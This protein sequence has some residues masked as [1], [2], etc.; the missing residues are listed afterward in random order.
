MLYAAALTVGTH[1]P[2]LRMGAAQ[3]PAPDKLV[4]MLAFGGL[5][6][7]FLQARWLRPGWL[8]GLV[9][10]AWTGL[11]EVSQALPGL[12]RTISFQDMLA[13]E[14]GVV[15]VV[16]WWWALLPLGGWPNRQRL[17]W[18]RFV[19]E[20]MFTRPATWLLVGAVGFAGGLAAAALVLAF[21]QVANLVLRDVASTLIA[22]LFLGG[23]AASHLALV[24]LARR[25]AAQQAGA[26]PCPDCGASCAEVDYDAEGQGRC[27]RCCGPIHRGLW[28]DPMEL[29]LGAVLKG[30]LPAA[31]AA[32]ALVAA[33][34]AVFVL[35]LIL[36]VRVA[37]ARDLLVIWQDLDSDMQLAIDLGAI[38]VSLAVGVR[39]YRM[40][41]AVLYDRQH[42]RC[43]ACGHDLTAAPRERGCGRCPECGMVFA[44]YPEAPG[45]G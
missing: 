38:G 9:V 5:A 10:L 32:A 3:Q 19:L 26:M 43:R 16:T 4:H 11:D 40:R 24:A 27:P 12:R 13:G 15:V 42:I 34:V 20:G 1:W 36:S 30:A 2:E 14:L 45:D 23:I 7:L 44:R 6:F 39:L 41:Q 17:R 18:Q 37:L 28:C 8:A 22:A 29:P 31:M 25:R 33:G 35:V 21:V